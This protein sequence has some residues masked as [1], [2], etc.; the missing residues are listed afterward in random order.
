MQQ[1][2]HQSQSLK[3]EQILAPQQI[4]SLEILLAS[5]QEL[6]VKI[7]EELAENPTLEQITP[8]NEDLVGDVL[9]DTESAQ[10][11]A[12]PEE[13]KNNEDDAVAEMINLAESWQNPIPF[14]T[15]GSYQH[16]EDDDKKREFLFDSLTAETSLQELL[17]EQ[18]RLSD[19]DEETVELGEL[20]IGSIDDSGYLRSILADLATAGNV[21]LKKMEQTLKFI[22][23]FDPPGIGARDPRECLLIQL[24]RQGKQKTLVYKLVSKHLDE[25]ASNKLPQVSK[26]MGISMEKLHELMDEIKLLN[27]YPGSALSP[28]KPVYIVPEVTI[29]EEDGEFKVKKEE[30][31]LPQLKISQY[32]IKLLENPSTTQDT[33]EYI[34]HKLA[35]SKALMKSITQRQ[36][37]IVQIAEVIL[38]TQYD[39]FKKGID[40]LHPL[41]MQQVAD[42]LGIHETTVSRAIANKYLQT[43][44]GLFEFKFFFSTGFQANDGAEVSNRSVMEKIKDI[45]AR[46]DTAKPYSDLKLTKLLKEEGLSV[47]RRTVAKYR[48]AIGIP[49]SHL[50]KEF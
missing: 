26:K 32:Y 20:V 13:K 46:E 18:L 29:I 1:G 45:I 19:A 21:T 34:R 14:S 25:L 12:T 7:S 47:A 27:P 48:E 11:Q 24:E 17:L 5:V 35:N 40:H 33:K 15:S 3:Q 37:T 43:P 23:S 4:Q 39:F 44:L 50:R 2:L 38:D 10:K 28:N 6:Q 36:R 9:S 42:K 22:Q 30:G 31:H 8:G 41:T 49:S 16:S